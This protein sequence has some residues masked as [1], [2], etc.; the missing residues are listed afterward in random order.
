MNTKEQAA[1]QE[2]DADCEV[3]VVSKKMSPG[4]AQKIS[5]HDVLVERRRLP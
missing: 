2:A 4:I 3:I 5:Q 1:R